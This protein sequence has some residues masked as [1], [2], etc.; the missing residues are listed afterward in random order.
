[1][2]KFG[3]WLC[4][5]RAP[6][7]GWTQ[8]AARWD[9]K[10]GMTP[11]GPYYPRILEPVMGHAE[12]LSELLQ[13]RERVVVPGAP[14]YPWLLGRAAEVRC[15][16]LV[17]GHDWHDGHLTAEVAAVQLALYVKRVHDELAQHLKLESPSCCRIGFPI[18]ATTAAPGR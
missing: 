4:V 18:Q 17:L 2:L 8:P 12:R 10:D 11:F 13:L 1:V 5:G 6:V 7:L 16:A 3:G 14:G 9:R 15:V